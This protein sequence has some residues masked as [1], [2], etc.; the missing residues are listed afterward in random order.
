[1]FIPSLIFYFFGHVAATN[2]IYNASQVEPRHLDHLDSSILHPSSNPDFLGDRSIYNIIW[3]CLATIF[4][5]TWIAVHPNLPAPKEGEV[6][7]FLRRLAIMGYL[8]LA[9]EMVIMWA[10]RQYLA[11][12]EISRRHQDKGWTKV[13]AFL[14]TMG[15]FMLFEGSVPLRTLEYNEFLQLLEQGRLDWPTVT[16][17]DINDK[18]K[19][20]YLSKGVV[21]LQTSWFIAQCIARGKFGLALT[22]LEIVTLA[23]AAITMLLYSLWWYKPLDIKIPFPVRLKEPAAHEGGLKALHISHSLPEMHAVRRS[24]LAPKEKTIPLTTS[25][26][27]PPPSMPV[28]ARGGTILTDPRPLQD[29]PSPQFQTLEDVPSHI[30]IPLTASPEPKSES[31]DHQISPP[32]S[33]TRFHAYLVHQQQKHGV[34]IGTAFVL[35]ISPFIPF[36]SSFDDMTSCSTLKGKQ[37]RVPTFYAQKVEDDEW[38]YLLGL[39]VALVFGGIH[40]IAWNFH[41]AS[42]PEMWMWRVAAILVCGVPIVIVFFSALIDG[43]DDGYSSRWREFLDNVDSGILMILTCLY[44]LARLALL[45]LPLI[46]LRSLPPSAFVDI[47]WTTF[48]PHI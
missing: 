2:I 44:M 7:V 17:E 29:P 10:S 33:L 18:S 38:S 5:C 9:P 16:E 30:P 37:F 40:C 36:F 39:V 13:H 47:N 4:A 46:G 21:L 8:L 1:M 22:E 11:A 35:F 31:I 32:S 15:G 19:G 20:D 43:G 23:F 34:I 14:F 24:E 48:I 42:F 25:V 26:P 28:A 3:S 41:F 45:I 12:L 27:H 6:Q